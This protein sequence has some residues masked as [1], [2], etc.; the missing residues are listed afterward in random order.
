[1]T[2]ISTR[3]LCHPSSARSLGRWGSIFREDVDDACFEDNVI[4][5]AVVFDETGQSRKV[6]EIEVDE[7]DQAGSVVRT[8]LT[9]FQYRAPGA[10]GVPGTCRVVGEAM[11]D[12]TGALR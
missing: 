1:V 2:E 4:V 5:S 11:L 3:L 6:A 10:F 12:C 8:L 9:T 7:A